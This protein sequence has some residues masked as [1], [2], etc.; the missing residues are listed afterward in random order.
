V[1]LHARRRAGLSQRALAQALGKANSHVTR[2]ERGQRRIDLLD[3]SR[4]RRRSVATRRS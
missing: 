3:S 4:W 1:L 2:I